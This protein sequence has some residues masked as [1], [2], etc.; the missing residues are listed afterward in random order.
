MKV[1]YSS[2]KINS[3]GGLNFTDSFLKSQGIYSF[4]DE[5]LGS[6]GL[7][8]K[9]KYSD[10]V[11]SLLSIVLCGGECAE[12]ITEH[13]REELSQ[14]H[15]Y[16]AP[17]ADTLLRMQK[18]LAGAKSTFTSDNGVKHEFADNPL[19]NGLLLQLLIKTG[20]LE[21]NQSDYVL[22][23][24]NQFIPTGK[25][26][27]KR[28]YKKAD[29]YFPGIASI[30]NMPVYIEG[31][32]GNSQVKYKQAQTL[33]KVYANLAAEGIKID[34]SRM[35]CG[36]FSKEIIEV[37]EQNSN[38]FYIRAQRCQSLYDIVCQIE[39]WQ[40]VEIG[41]IIYQVASVEYAPFQDKKTYRY[42]ISREKV[43]TNQGNL[44]TDESFKYRA[45]ITNDRQMSDLE[46]IQFYNAR[47]NSE[48]LF[49]E[50]NNDFLWKKMPFSFLEQNTVY[51]IIM[52]ICRNLY[53]FLLQRISEKIS[54]VKTSFRLKRFIFRFMTV[55][56][57][58]TYRGRQWMLR[59]F[60]HKPY[61]LL[62]E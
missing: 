2:K 52:A 8:A 37:V 57:Q 39:N 36:S 20:Q 19:L 56:A 35:D 32:N 12:D 26:D 28:S 27:A 49:D 18:E 29:G 10:L 30:N 16:E 5:Q 59:L 55:P 44:F 62:L 43:E 60:T 9:Y 38:L 47:G 21:K 42:V 31:R 33:K 3:F 54:F 6:R 24:D 1:T 46:V 50:M 7:F 48:R 53:H 23:Y 4:I 40:E 58:W 15:G 14:L 45:I 51:L 41:H 61:H 13:L 25:Y 17:S 11:R 22:D 34:K